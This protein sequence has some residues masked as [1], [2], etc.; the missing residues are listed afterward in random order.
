MTSVRKSVVRTEK[1]EGLERKKAH[2]AEKPRKRAPSAPI[3]PKP[4]LPTPVASFEV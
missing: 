3:R 1:K 4:E 2:R